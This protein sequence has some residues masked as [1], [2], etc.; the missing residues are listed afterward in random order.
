VPAD[1]VAVLALAVLF[2]AIVAAT[3]QRWGTPEI[4]A[5]A[6]LTA[7]DR[8]AH[9]AMPYEDVRYFY[10]PL[11]L[12]G[13]ALAFK[14]AGTSF[15]V[16][17][18]FG[19]LLTFAIIGVVY[20]LARRWLPPLTAALAAA[21]TMAIAFSGTA[22]DFAL[23]HT[24]SATTGLLCL[25]L[26]LL[27]ISR[28]R[29][30]WA[31]VAA[32]LTGLTR[33]EFAAVAAAVLVASLVGVWRDAGPGAARAA[34]V[35]ALVPAA[36]IPTLVLGLLAASVGAARLFT[37]NLWPVD[38]I[39]ANGLRAQSDWMPFTLASA[40]GLA[41]RAAIY[42][43]LLA[44]L[45][46]VVAG[47]R[48]ARG[49]GE[50]LRSLWPLAALAAA[51][52]IA[53]AA[54]RATGM[55]ETTR[56]AVEEEARHLVLGMSWLPALAIGA[57]LWGAIR[58]VRGR[59]APLSGSWAVDLALL[60]AAAGLTLRAY[61]AFTTE[62]SYAP[63]YAAPAV[64]LLAILHERVGGRVP[65]ARPAARAALGLVALG[66]AAFALH[67]L[68]GD[69]SEPVRTARGTFVTAPA[70]APALQ[71][72]LD[73]VAAGD[74]SRPILAA[75]ADGG[76]YFMTGRRPALTDVMLL[77]GLLDSAADERDAIARL[78]AQRVQTAVV[79]TRDMSA[80]GP[81][82][83]GHDYNARL[84]SYLTTRATRSSAYGDQSVPASGTYPSR[85]FVVL[86]LSP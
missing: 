63:Y 46:A 47:W 75:P 54:A 59:V 26:C 42:L 86:T 10:G 68:Y 56:L 1:V 19:L 22:F 57:G 31:G 85:G 15:T 21:V 38:F 43:G 51:V 41:I 62:A 5:G 2:A 49:R 70:A 25:L 80:F 34:A 65:A 29:W 64:I 72:T 11:G 60:A 33:P 23:P 81:R 27:A 7:A 32:G 16:A 37:E 61:N 83:F 50:R 18:A 69:D 4:D 48:G 73:A 6:E 55:G 17:F 28:D 9:G 24:N 35:R 44:A 77:P 30:I 14:L 74:P 12:Y 36:A 40:G 52:L 84:G 78:Q 53:E 66:L 20:A 39:R 71:G 45:V 76:L 67:G 82:R 79:A 3:W 13:L 58:L 8:V